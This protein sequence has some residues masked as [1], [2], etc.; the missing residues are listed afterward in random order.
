MS[1]KKYVP[2]TPQWQPMR[3]CQT[4]DGEE[5]WGNNRYTAKRNV[6][7]ADH[8]DAPIIVHLSIHDHKRSATHDWRDLQRIKNEVCGPE[9]EAVE[10]YPP[11]SCLVDTA[12]EY[13]LW[14]FADG[15]GLTSAGVGFRE[16][17]VSEV[18]GR[19]IG[20][21]AVARTRQRPWPEGQKPKDLVTADQMAERI[22]KF[23]DIKA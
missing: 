13:H 18:D 20:L 21:D 22:G 17:L 1:R 4:L 23:L 8:P 12:N 7:R 15:E 9:C 5:I 2:Y 3:L 14:V 11:E 19:A 6:L 16:R 10:I